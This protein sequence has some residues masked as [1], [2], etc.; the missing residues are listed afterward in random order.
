VADVVLLQS[1][2]AKHDAPNARLQRTVAGSVRC[3]D[4]GR[5]SQRGARLAR[6]HA[7]PAGPREEHVH[8]GDA[9]GRPRRR[10]RRRGWGGEAHRRRRCGL[11]QR[12]VTRTRATWGD[13][14]V[15]NDVGPGTRRRC[16][17][18]HW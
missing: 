15:H 14:H 11:R 18:G 1:A 12:L 13:G 2:H 3:D 4:S 10:F 17:H 16:D 9:E 8:A 6:A 7:P 5:H